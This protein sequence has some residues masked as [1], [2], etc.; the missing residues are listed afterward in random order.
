M[1]PTLVL[2]ALVLGLVGLLVA[3]GVKYWLFLRYLRHRRD[4]ERDL[5]DQTERARALKSLAATDY[6]KGTR[7][8]PS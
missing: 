7:R 1:S 3:V 6:A 2:T 8:K 5:V 4:R